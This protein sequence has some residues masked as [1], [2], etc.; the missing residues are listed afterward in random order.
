M[1]EANATADADTIAEAGTTADED[2]VA[3]SVA[4]TVMPNF[5]YSKIL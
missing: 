2:A 1:A 4:H 5:L 3:V